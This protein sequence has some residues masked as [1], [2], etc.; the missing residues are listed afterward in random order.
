MRWY[1]PIVWWRLLWWTPLQLFRWLFIFCAYMG[2]GVWAAKEL[3]RD[4]R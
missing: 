3:I 1:S 2:W 4:T